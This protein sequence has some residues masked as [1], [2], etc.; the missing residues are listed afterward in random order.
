MLQL[1][2]NSPEGIAR[3]TFTVNGSRIEVHFNPETLT[4]TLARSLS[5]RGAVPG[6]QADSNK[7]A[8]SAQ[9]AGTFAVTLGMKLQFD[10]T[11]SGTDVRE[12]TIKFQRMMQPQD[13]GQKSKIVEFHWGTFKFSG[14][15]QSYTETID[16]FSAEG[17]PL[18]ASVDLSMSEN[19]EVPPGQAGAGGAGF[20]FSAGIE[21][22]ARAGASIS[23][24]IG[25]DALSARA[26]AEFNGE[27]SVRRLSGAPL[28]VNAEV[29]LNGPVAFATG[30]AS[31]GASIGVG[32]GANASI[33]VGGGLGLQLSAGAGL[34]AGI[35]GGIGIGGGLNV[36]GGL[37]IGIGAAAGG[38]GPA[39]FGF[40]GASLSSVASA[41]GPPLAPAQAFATDVASRV[42]A[43][44][45]AGI[46]GASSGLLSPAVGSFARSSGVAF[47]SAAGA[48]AAANLV[49]FSARDPEPTQLEGP[50]WGSRAS[51]GI[52]AVFGAFS[53]LQASATPPRIRRRIDPNRL[54]P[55]QPD[56][57]LHADA[58]SAFEIGGRALSA[59]ASGLSADV[60]VNAS[61]SDRIQFDE[62]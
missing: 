7:P 36:A 19:Q 3:A 46:A 10:S 53:G 20:G 62:E 40:A 25:G 24:S 56:A 55:R 37:D 14:T 50:A 4:L 11:D 60:G 21:I 9:E 38:V 52:P 17:V 27:A 31:F 33:G 54:L 30:S 57:A 12:T 45:A 22:G 43:A 51:A 58:D 1:G 32:L 6:S 42:G 15:F 39:Q 35:G 61:L 41:G 8:A 34:G 28:E 18:R 13:G 29:S 16:F 59:Q 48:R 23:A 5:G 26:V 44:A 49:A 2:N 47:A